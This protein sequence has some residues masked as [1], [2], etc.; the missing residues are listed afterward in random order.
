M[1]WFGSFWFS[2]SAEH[3]HV[4]TYLCN[5]SLHM[6]ICTCLFACPSEA[7]S[8]P[9]QAHSSAFF[10]LS[11]HPPNNS[12]FFFFFFSFRWNSCG[13]CFFVTERANTHIH[14]YSFFSYLCL[15][16]IRSFSQPKSYTSNMQVQVCR[17]VYSQTDVFSPGS[18]W[19]RYVLHTILLN[20]IK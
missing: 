18:R 16:V 17:T 10:S 1:V 7:T 13:R 6:Y 5:H 2:G 19:G 11:S 20:M 14:S 15:I 12:T 3:V 9:E 8:R 4:R